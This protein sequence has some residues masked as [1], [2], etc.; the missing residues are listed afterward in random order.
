MVHAMMSK[1]KEKYH[2][3]AKKADL[4]K[5]MKINIGLTACNAWARAKHFVCHSVITL[6]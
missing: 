6:A 2:V 4:N 1:H 3:R 5:Q